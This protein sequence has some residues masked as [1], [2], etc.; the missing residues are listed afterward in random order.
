MIWFDRVRHY[1][2]GLRILKDWWVDGT[3]PVDIDEA[4]RRA[5]ICLG[6]PLNQSGSAVVEAVAR[7]IKEQVDL[8]NSLQLRVKGEKSLKTC[9]ACLCY[10]RLKIWLP[11]E[12]LIR[13]ADEEEMNRYHPKCWMRQKP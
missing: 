3:H 5:D 12:N 7:A 9:Q 10:L 13:Y 8:K 1:N 11:L 4:Q 2:D 6:C